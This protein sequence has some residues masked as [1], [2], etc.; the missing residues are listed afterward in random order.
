MSGIP[1]EVTDLE[2]IR[3]SCVEAYSGLNGERGETAAKLAA[4]G[5]GTVAV[6]CTPSGGA[7]SLR[8]DL[9]AAWDELSE[10]DLVAAIARAR[11]SK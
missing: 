10:E 5:D 3:W 4:N 9:P 2:Q 1:R 6:V 11:S 7:Q 8:L